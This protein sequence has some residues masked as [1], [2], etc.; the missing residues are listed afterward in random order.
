MAFK[1]NI[2]DKEG[3]SWKLEAEAESLVGKSVSDKFNGKDINADFDGYEMEVTGG[4]DK[5]GFP[6]SKDV[7]GIGLKRVLLKKGWGMH[8][9]PKGLKKKK[10]STPDGMRLRKTI[11]GKKIAESTS[12]INIKILKEGSK[13]LSEIFPE[14]NKPKEK[15]KKEEAP[16]PAEEK[17]E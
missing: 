17:K 4:S 15:A 2:S 8:R 10:V 9:K 16:K 14:Q 1:L 13:K 7:E 6:L 11:R 5:S 3:K 12:Q